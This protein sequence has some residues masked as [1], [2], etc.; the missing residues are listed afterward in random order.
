MDLKNL[1]NLFK[2][3]TPRREPKRTQRA[4]L[5]EN[6]QSIQ[7]EIDNQGRA[8]AAVAAAAR[9]PGPQRQRGDQGRGQGQ[10]EEAACE[11]G[12]RL[13]ARREN[14]GEGM[15]ALRRCAPRAYPLRD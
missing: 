8:R 5:L 3:V 9:A 11:E 2:A 12:L 13:G 7:V 14:R 15:S 6:L 10:G 1:G 4:L